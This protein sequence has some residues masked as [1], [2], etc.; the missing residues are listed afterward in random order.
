V[1]I[2][3]HDPSAV[4]E[5]SELGSYPEMA[6]GGDVRPERLD[7]RQ[8]CEREPLVANAER[9]AFGVVVDQP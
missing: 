7:E 6:L 8:Q 1:S 2:A 9:F 5:T 3:N 4:A